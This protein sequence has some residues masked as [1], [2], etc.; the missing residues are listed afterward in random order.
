M[1]KEFPQISIA[2][3]H[4]DVQLAKE[5]YIV[6][7]HFDLLSLLRCCLWLKSLEE[8][9][10]ILL[11]WLMHRHRAIFKNFLNKVSILFDAC[12][13]QCAL[14]H[15][16]RFIHA[17]ATVKCTHSVE[18]FKEAVNLLQKCLLCCNTLLMVLKIPRVLCISTMKVLFLKLL[19][20]SNQ[21]WPD[22]IESLNATGFS[23]S[24]IKP[25]ELFI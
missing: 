11:Y 16:H 15:Y 22:S 13:F 21:L 7:K 9:K 25:S 17:V 8:S 1:S 10:R 19:L 24:S 14:G 20:Q 4:G 3:L 6:L 5:C 12:V 2:T 23:V 18:C